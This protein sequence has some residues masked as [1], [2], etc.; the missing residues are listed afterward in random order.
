MEVSEVKRLRALGSKNGNI[1][2]LLADIMLWNTTEG[3]AMLLYQ[4]A[5]VAYA[6]RGHR[7]GNAS[8][9]VT[10]TP[11]HNIHATLGARFMPPGGNWLWISDT[12]GQ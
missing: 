12:H 9:S 7:L 8:F 11:V 1:K 5:F 2:R 4:E 6:G 3:T 10:N